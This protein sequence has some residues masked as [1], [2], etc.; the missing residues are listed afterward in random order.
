[1]RSSLKI[2]GVLVLVVLGRVNRYRKLRYRK[3]FVKKLFREKTFQ[4]TGEQVGAYRLRCRTV[5][6]VHYAFT[7]NM[8]LK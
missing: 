3:M 5:F 4:Q 7:L 8:A 2:V 6:Y 1:M